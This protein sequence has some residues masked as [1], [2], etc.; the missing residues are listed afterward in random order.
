MT[1]SQMTL[2]KMS[3]N[4]NIVKASKAGDKAYMYPIQFSTILHGHE[5]EMLEDAGVANLVKEGWTTDDFEKV[6]KAL[7]DKGYTPGSL[8]S[9]GQ[10]ET[11]EHVPSSQTL[12]RFCNR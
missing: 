6:L 1:S 7:K 11:K 3:N 4:E 5:Q 8:F 10:G 12:R 2:L 9:S